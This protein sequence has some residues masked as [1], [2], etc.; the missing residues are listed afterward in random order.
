MGGYFMKNITKLLLAILLVGIIEPAAFAMKRDAGEISGNVSE[1]PPLLPKILKSSPEWEKFNLYEFAEK[2]FKN[3]KEYNSKRQRS[4]QQVKSVISNSEFL[5]VL[6]DFIQLHSSDSSPLKFTSPESWVNG[7]FPKPGLYSQTETILNYRHPYAQRLIL[8][9]GE[10]IFFKGDIHGSIHSLIRDFLRCDFL[11]KNLKIKNSHQKMIF[12][13]DYV[14]RGRYGIEVLYLL[15]I[16]KLRNPT[17]V[18]LLRG[19]HEDPNME[20]RH[21]IR[22]EIKERFEVK[23]I[24]LTL[25]RL[26]CFYDLLPFVL[27]LGC[28]NSYAQ[29]CHGGIEPA[30]N[31]R[32]LL[33][34]KNTNITY[35]C[36][37]GK[38]EPSKFID[39]ITKNTAFKHFS[40][41]EQMPV[42]P[43]TNF[44]CPGFLWNDFCRYYNTSGNEIY[45]QSKMV[46]TGHLCVAS[47]DVIQKYLTWLNNTQLQTKTSGV[48]LNCIIRGHQHSDYV[49]M[50]F[51]PEFNTKFRQHKTSPNASTQLP[52]S[53]IKD[54]KFFATPQQIYSSIPLEMHKLF[55][56]FTLTAAPEGVGNDN[57]HGTNVKFRRDGF[58]II[59]ID[60]DYK[61][62]KLQPHDYPIIRPEK[63]TGLYCS[64]RNGNTQD[65]LKVEF[66]ENPP[67]KALNFTKIYFDGYDSFID[68]QAETQF[69]QLKNSLNP[70]SKKDP[71]PQLTLPINPK[72]KS[73]TL[74]HLRV[75]N[76]IKK[77][78]EQTLVKMLDKFGQ[79]SGKPIHQ[80]D[81]PH[82]L[83]QVIKPAIAREMQHNDEFY[84]FYHAHP[85][86]NDSPQNNILL[87]QDILQRLYKWGLLNK[88]QPIPVRTNVGQ[89]FDFPKT[90][91]NFLDQTQMCKRD[92]YTGLFSCPF[93][94]KESDNWFDCMSCV[95]Y[96]LLAVNFSLFGY[97]DQEMLG[98]CSFWYFSQKE[99][100][101]PPNYIK[102]TLEELFRTCKIEPKYLDKIFEPFFTTKENGTAGCLLQIFINK[103]VVDQ[104]AYFAIPGGKPV[105]ERIIE[106][107]W[108]DRKERHTQ[109]SPFLDLYQN[110][111]GKL[112]RLMQ[113]FRYDGVSHH[114]NCSLNLS[115]ARLFATSPI[116]YD[117]KLVKTYRY[118]TPGYL[119]QEESIKYYQELDEI[120]EC[121][122]KDYFRQSIK[123]HH[124]DNILAGT[125]VSALGHA[126]NR[127]GYTGACKHF[128][129]KHGLFLPT[130]ANQSLRDPALELESLLLEACV[131][132]TPAIATSIQQFIKAFDYLKLSDGTT[133]LMF[134]LKRNNLPLINLILSTKEY[135]IKQQ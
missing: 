115:Q 1:Q 83:N 124:I 27:Y 13:G 105:Y 24:N 26:A 42:G 81:Y 41:E 128:L 131:E 12:L 2:C 60:P 9:K 82:Y 22:D 101:N 16:L 122:I 114:Y 80:T 118:F 129:D 84:C 121:I 28:Q 46:F 62:W 8:D 135:D 25:E 99:C 39:E 113:K 127:I 51:D 67:I 57:A 53:Q 110:A 49:I 58:G 134:A 112:D 3:L 34:E 87:F 15:M 90:L 35:E 54:W 21:T 40:E 78:T 109:I 31:P 23:N 103:S 63:S 94:H 4:E 111:P 52:E 75:F 20:V 59:T 117:P 106:D 92:P 116:L 38:N 85:I 76:K 29:C 133:P 55:P 98:D 19:N 74:N 93:C 126:V 88:A 91:D 36:L 64:I 37:L 107:I 73:Q 96:Q 125:S 7:C 79:I 30:Y 97:L 123:N 56:V 5:E 45:N 70:E 14:D 72:L 108:D 102:Q 69:K 66:T 77:I 95:S 65:P 120:F 43:R 10:K 86:Q 104:I 11:D 50:M 119:T 47:F 100:A 61:K 44:Y 33:L 68:T 89:K 130:G 18:F 6:N 17:S 132:L 48:S 32:N 71:I